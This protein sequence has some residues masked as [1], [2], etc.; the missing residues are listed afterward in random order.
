MDY[1]FDDGLILIKVLRKLE[2]LNI[3]NKIIS[4]FI[5]H[6]NPHLGINCSKL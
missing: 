2:L 4:Y 5:I 6:C 3:H 1:L